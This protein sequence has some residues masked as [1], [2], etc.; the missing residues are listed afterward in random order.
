MKRLLLGL[1]AGCSEAGVHG[2]LVEMG[3]ED[4]AHRARFHLGM[5]QPF[6]VELQNWLSRSGD[7]PP[8][9]TRFFPTACAIIEEEFSKATQAVMRE[10][11]L[12]PGGAAAAACDEYF[13]GAEQSLKFQAFQDWGPGFSLARQTGL[14]VAALHPSK[15]NQKNSCHD[16][17]DFHA[18][19]AASPHD[20]PFLILNLGGSIRLTAYVPGREAITLPEAPCGSFL[21][22]FSSPGGL[23]SPGVDPL[24]KKAVQGKCKE[25][26]LTRWRNLGQAWLQAPGKNPAEYLASLLGTAP[27]LEAPDLLCTAHY[28]VVDTIL[29]MLGKLPKEFLEGRWFLTGPHGRNGLFRQLLAMVFSGRKLELSDTLG[30]PAPSW[31]AFTRGV[32]GGLAL[33]AL[34]PLPG[35]FPRSNSPLAAFHPGGPVSWSRCLDWMNQGLAASA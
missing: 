33:G 16:L 29:A 27:A 5:F 10:S 11:K 6:T 8:R 20:F 30:I 32:L 24:A 12:G 17:R 13:A 15:N 28:F 2:A 18:L 22:L 31:D 19:R 21:E 25:D 9:E 35:Y 1:H 7:K 3:V 4:Q 34:A 23:P 26:L 14:T